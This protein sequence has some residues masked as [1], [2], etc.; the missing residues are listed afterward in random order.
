MRKWEHDIVPNALYRTKYTVSRL[1]YTFDRTKCSSSSFYSGSCPLKASV[2]LT[3]TDTYNSQRYNLWIHVLISTKHGHIFQA[4]QAYSVDEYN[5]MRL[6]QNTSTLTLLP[7]QFHS[8]LKSDQYQITIHS[9]I[10][11]PSQQSQDCQI[12]PQC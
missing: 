12:T 5:G 7:K 4:P 8:V 2:Q 10:A 6:F 9:I 11:E 1:S 3:G